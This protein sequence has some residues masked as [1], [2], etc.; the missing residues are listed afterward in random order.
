MHVTAQAKDLFSIAF[1]LVVLSFVLTVPH[2]G[3]AS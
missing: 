2:D 1:E 3:H